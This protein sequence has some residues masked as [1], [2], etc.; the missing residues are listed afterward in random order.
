VPI[1]EHSCSTNKQQ[2]QS[3]SLLVFATHP[4][5]IQTVSSSVAR[6]TSRSTSISISLSITHTH[7]RYDT[8]LQHT[9][10]APCDF[11]AA[12][13]AIVSVRG[14]WQRCMTD[15]AREC[16]VIRPSAHIHT[17]VLIVVSLVCAHRMIVGMVH[18][19][20]QSSRLVRNLTRRW[21][22]TLGRSWSCS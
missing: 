1:E 4:H 6:A 7:S 17:S 19:C 9:T 14:Q 5:T 2:Y 16:C 21:Y 11:G 20:P 15:G 13:G 8:T 12:V 10:I 18:N 3:N 22:S